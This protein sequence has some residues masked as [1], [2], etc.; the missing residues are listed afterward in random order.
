MDAQD[1][2][3]LS[4]LLDQALDLPAPERAAWLAAQPAGS[5]RDELARMLA[6]HASLSTQGPFE[7]LPNL[8][9]A[10][11]PA[12]AGERIGPYRLL[13]ELGRGGMGSVWLAERA[14]GA[15]ERQVALKLPR[16]AWSTEL[17][18]RLEREQRISARLEHA[19]IA[20]L[21]DAGRDA[22][23]R[24]F[25]AMEYVA[26]RPIDRHVRAAGLGQPAVLALLRQVLGA[27]AY[28]HAQGVVHRDLKPAN[29]LIAADDTPRLLDFG[30]AALLGA[31]GDRAHTPSHAAPEQIAGGEAS[32]AGDVY[33]L[34]LMFAALLPAALAPE[35][36]AIL[37]KARA[38]APSARYPDASAFAADL[39]RH[40]AGQAVAARPD[41]PAQALGRWLR[42]RRTPA[43]AALVVVLLGAAAFWQTQLAARGAWRAQLAAQTTQRQALAQLGAYRL[44]ADA[45]T[46]RIELLARGHA[47]A[48][49]QAQAALDQARDLL[50]ARDFAAAEAA[51]QSAAADP[52]SAGE[53]RLLIARS[54]L[55][56]QRTDEALP[57]IAAI[58]ASQPS[59]IQAAWAQSLRAQWLQTAN[60]RDEAL[61]LH[62]QAVALA[63]AS[64]G[65]H[66]L[67][68]VDLHLAAADGLLY[69]TH[70][71][72]ARRH[73]AA[74]LATLNALGGEH[75]M[76][77]A[78]LDAR[79]AAARY[80]GYFQIDAD[81]AL[82]AL[83][84]SRAR[85]AQLEGAGRPLPP[86]LP[87]QLDLWEASILARQGEPGSANVLFERSQ[88]TLLALARTPAERLRLGHTQGEI[89]QLLGRFDAADAGYRMALQARID[90]GMARHPAIA[91]NYVAAALN[92][93]DAGRRDQALALLDQAPHFEPVRGE[94]TR[95]PERYNHLIAYGRARV[96][97][98]AG[99]ADEALAALPAALL[100]PGPDRVSQYDAQLALALRGEARCLSAGT[101]A[102]GWLDLKRS[103]AL[104]QTTR[105]AGGARHPEIGRLQAV[106][107]EC[108]LRLGDAP[109]A[110]R[111]AALART[112]L[113]AH[114]ELSD[115]LRAPLRR[116]DAGLALRPRRG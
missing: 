95:N 46:Q 55:A 90:G 35:L 81:E 36:A 52:A 15:F 1:L 65:A 83:R 85:L 47:S 108:A 12:Q 74:A 16:L 84:G 93:S 14:D 56:R 17:A 109:T 69:T 101:A 86:E 45:G 33:S 3:T 79:Y 25:I 40:L 82:T 94:G 59:G 113:A 8:A 54:L 103:L 57:L 97:L 18:E 6:D 28:A 89:N 60:R 43:L 96:L 20:R 27:V 13:H 63:Q 50:D 110:R 9:G 58:E 80:L 92:L 64:G 111:L 51:A 29:V 62:E 67:D 88:A 30:I 42:R 73:I 7:S 66:S 105:D 77:A 114:A 39:D 71:E 2:A 53:A 41:S 61:R 5:V 106:A 22:H 70:A 23:G 11:P 34:G 116:L 78:F 48:P 72:A 115:Y 49:E 37:A 32:P 112:A 10:T 19:H 68:A 99:R 100:A 24:P 104:A 31:S 38:A 44:A 21:Y 26:G 98:D 107:G 87:A 75:A 4:G 102:A 76:R 91:F